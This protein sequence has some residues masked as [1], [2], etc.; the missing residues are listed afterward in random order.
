MQQRGT[1]SLAFRIV[2]FAIPSVHELGLPQVCKEL[3]LKPRGLILVTGAAASGKSTTLYEIQANIEMGRLEGMQ[4]LDQAL[5]D[6]VRSKPVDREE[7]LLRS[8]SPARLQQL[9]QF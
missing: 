9:L 8:R 6:L 1:L 2:P 3:I 4:T 5:A 7:A